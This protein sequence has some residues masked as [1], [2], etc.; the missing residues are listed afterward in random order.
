MHVYAAS[1]LSALD[2]CTASRTTCEPLGA[3][4]LRITLTDPPRIISPCNVQ[5][6]T[7]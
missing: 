6:Q 1:I 3:F 4:R 5:P 2:R 7:S